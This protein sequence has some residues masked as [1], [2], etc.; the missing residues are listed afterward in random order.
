M[1]KKVNGFHLNKYIYHQPLKEEPILL[2]IDDISDREVESQ[3]HDDFVE[4]SPVSPIEG[5][6]RSG[7]III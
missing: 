6:T 1:K 5:P 3:P 4:S 7:I 2:P